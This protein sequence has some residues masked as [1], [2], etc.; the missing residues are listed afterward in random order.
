MG[1][2]VSHL[3]PPKAVLGFYPTPLHKLE[4]LSQELGV[5]LYLKRDDLSGPNLF[6][7]NKI[8]KLEY[9]LGDATTY[10]TVI[11]FGAT[12]SNHAMQTAVAARK[13]GLEVILYLTTITEVDDT[14]DRGNILIDHVLGAE[15][16]YISMTGRTLTEANAIS[17]EV[18][19]KQKEQLEKSGRKVKIVPFGGAAALGSIGFIQGYKELLDQSPVSLDYIVH[20]TGTGST[21][22][23]LVAGSKLYSQPGKRPKII[24]MDVLE[25]AYDHPTKMATLANDALQ[26]MAVAPS[27]SAS[28]FY[29]EPHYLQPGYEIPSETAAAAIRRLARTEG[30]LLDPVYTGKGFAGLL[31][32]IETGKIPPNSKVVFWHTGGISALFAESEMVGKLY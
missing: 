13:L 19:L 5:E 31:D 11:T 17:M 1:N 7:G 26:L 22:A 4:R 3:L 32:Y 15:V 10:D 28:D 9:L 23:G 24:S 2:K 27:V 30:I 12:Q 25:H 18:A 16:H 14:Q 6:G 29:F 20:T 8:R 21:A